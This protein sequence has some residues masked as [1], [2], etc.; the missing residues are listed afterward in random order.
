MMM[1]EDDWLN[2]RKIDERNVFIRKW[3]KFKF[4]FFCCIKF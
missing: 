4:C 1:S 2:L 3:S